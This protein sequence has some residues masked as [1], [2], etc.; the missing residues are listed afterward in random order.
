MGD[1]L[2]L[3]TPEGILGGRSLR[4]V[5][6]QRHSRWSAIDGIANYGM[7]CFSALLATSGT[8]DCGGR[9]M[10][11]R[12]WIRVEAV[13]SVGSANLLKQR[14]CRGYMTSMLGFVA[15]HHQSSRRQEKPMAVRH[16]SISGVCVTHPGV[17]KAGTTPSCVSQDV[18]P[19]RRF[20]RKELARRP[21]IGRS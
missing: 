11:L 17:L 4:R 10:I 19:L 20:G 16:F 15:L 7:L 2:V 8:V 21:L 9:W 3:A 1:G 13:T 14:C 5:V 12:C 6:R 18:L